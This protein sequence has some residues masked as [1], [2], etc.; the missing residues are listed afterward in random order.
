MTILT[1]SSETA[2]ITVTPTGKLFACKLHYRGS[3]TFLQLN[4]P[5]CHQFCAGTLR[6]TQWEAEGSIFR[7]SVRLFGDTCGGKK[8]AQLLV[9]AFLLGSISEKETVFSLKLENCFLIA[10]RLYFQHALLILFHFI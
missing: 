4:R 7:K 5:F 10:Q 3:Q 2:P 1:L 9:Y 8:S 6:V